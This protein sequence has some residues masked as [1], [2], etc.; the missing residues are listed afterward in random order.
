MNTVSSLILQAT[1]VQKNEPSKLT[2]RDTKHNW[3]TQ[4]LGQLILTKLRDW[5]TATR[6]PDPWSEDEQNRADDQEALI[7]C[8]RCCTP[9]GA[10]NWFCPGCGTAVGPY[11]NVLP[12]VYIF[13]IGEVF[14]SGMCSSAKY[15]SLTVPGY[16]FASMIQYGLFCPFY[17][18][19]LCRNCSKQRKQGNDDGGLH[20]PSAIYKTTLVASIMACVT[21]IISVYLL[22]YEGR[23]DANIHESGDCAVL[24]YDLYTGQVDVRSSDPSGTTSL[25]RFNMQD[26]DESFP[27]PQPLPESTNFPSHFYRIGQGASE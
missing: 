6:P 23:E 7:V 15:T 5:W 21:T 3:G 27:A 16:I 25:S 12:F 22:F 18:V 11:N 14:R 10:P 13:S 20:P 9:Q 26:S 2:M 19:R 8:H 24:R 1:D 17:L 4:S